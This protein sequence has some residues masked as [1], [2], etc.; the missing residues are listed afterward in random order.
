V[1]LYADEPGHEAVRALG[2]LVVSCLARVEVPAALWRKHRSGEL[3]AEAARVLAA[4]F[5]ADY[6]GAGGAGQRFV[7]LGLPPETL[8]EAARLVVAH[9]IRAYDAVQLA[10]AVA[11]READAGCGS[12]ACFDR[13][14]R[15][16]AVAESFSLIP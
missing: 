6:A 9:G 15:R 13:R 12:V 11:A 3:E 14:L 4:E 1:K 5:E 16:A 7:V 8:E 10:S 2:P